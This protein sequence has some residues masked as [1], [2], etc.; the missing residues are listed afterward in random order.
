MDPIAEYNR[1]AAEANRLSGENVALRANIMAW[2]QF[3][4]SGSKHEKYGFMSIEGDKPGFI[5]PPVAR[6]YGFMADTMQA[7]PC[8]CPSFG[9]AVVRGAGL[10]V[11]IGFVTALAAGAI[12]LS[13]RK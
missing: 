3:A 4:P 10:A 13:R 9:S 6:K 12:Y 7:Q 5:Y 11:G 8:P 2:P 1:L